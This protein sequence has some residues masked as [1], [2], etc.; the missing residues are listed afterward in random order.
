MLIGSLEPWT[1]GGVYSGGLVTHSNGFQLGSNNGFSPAGLAPVIL[2]GVAALNGSLRLADR[3]VPRVLDIPLGITGIVGVGV[4]L[5]GLAEARWYTHQMI[6]AYP[7]IF[8]A[9]AS[10]GSWLVCY[11]GLAILAIAAIAFDRPRRLGS[12]IAIA[13]ILCLLVLV[14]SL[15]LAPRL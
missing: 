2:G 14:S 15:A 6:A 3:V 1:Y 5:Y 12:R 8:Y 13:L 7:K 9:G 4:G 10:Y 11:G